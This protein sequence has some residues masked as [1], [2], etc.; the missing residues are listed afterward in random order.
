MMY[1]KMHIIFNSFGHFRLSLPNQKIKFQ[2]K[3]HNELH[4]FGQAKLGYGGLVFGLS[5]LTQLPHL[6]QKMTLASKAVKSNSKI[7]ILLC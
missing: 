1:F 4:R 5:Q 7:L 2:D 3:L 6:A